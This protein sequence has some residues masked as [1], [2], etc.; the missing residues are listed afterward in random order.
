MVFN[1]AKD[2]PDDFVV[3]ARKLEAGG[4]PCPIVIHPDLYHDL[5]RYYELS[6]E[7]MLKFLGAHLVK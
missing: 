2:H 6:C 5:G 4:V 1:G 3:L 7:P